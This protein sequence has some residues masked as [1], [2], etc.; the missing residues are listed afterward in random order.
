VAGG[1]SLFEF[2]ENEDDQ[3]TLPSKK[4]ATSPST[5]PPEATPSAEASAAAP[6]EAKGKRTTADRLAAAQSRVIGRR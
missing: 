1:G 2:L 5:A 4:P 6:K 3:V